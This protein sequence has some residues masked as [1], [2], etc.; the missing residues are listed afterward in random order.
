MCTLAAK[1]FP[2]IG[3]VGAKNRDRSSP[4]DSKLVRHIEN[5]LEKVTLVDDK[6]HWSEGMNDN[7]ISIISSSLTPISKND[8]EEHTSKNGFRIKEALTQSTVKDAVKSL[9]KS[10]ATGCIMIFD[11]DELWLLEGEIK[12][13]KQIVR[14]ITDNMI[15]RTNHGVWIP[16][17]G[18]QPNDSNHLLEMRRISSEARLL[19]ADFIVNVA[20]NPE[21][22]MVLLAHQ[23]SVNPQLTT[24][25]D[26]TNQIQTRTTEQLL[27]EPYRNIILLRNTD[28]KLDFNQSDANQPNSKVLV[29]I[30]N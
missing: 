5:G 22:L 12:T 24:L 1:K 6:T 20:K 9:V 2:N 4:T 13:H 19:I 8:S 26:P 25:R 28:G 3:W 17:A 15:A 14:R 21:D 16:S 30:L 29:G 18:Y 7:G 27:L 23:W 10:K 11:K